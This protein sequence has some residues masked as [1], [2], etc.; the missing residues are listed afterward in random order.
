ME[1]SLLLLLCLVI[2]LI[3][4]LGWQGIKRM[5]PDYDVGEEWG[6]D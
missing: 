2:A 6:D 4:C 3:G 1:Y 5:F